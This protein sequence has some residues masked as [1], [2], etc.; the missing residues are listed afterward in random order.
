M[1]A[2][3]AVQASLCNWARADNNTI[4]KVLSEMSDSEARLLNL[5]VDGS[6]VDEILVDKE[7]K[8]TP[9]SCKMIAWVN[10]MPGGPAKFDVQRQVMPWKGNSAPAPYVEQSYIVTWNGRVGEYLEVKI[11]SLGN[12]HESTRAWVYSKPPPQLSYPQDAWGAVFSSNF[13]FCW[14]SKTL[15]QHIASDVSEW[16]KQPDKIYCALVNEVLNGSQTIK[17]SIGRQHMV[18]YDWWIDPK[19]GSSLLRYEYHAYQPDGGVADSYSG[20]VLEL[21][22]AAPEVWY[23]KEGVYFYSPAEIAVLDPGQKLPRR[24]HF[25][26]NNVVANDAK[27]DPH[28][29]D[30]SFPPGYF[31]V[32]SDTGKVNVTGPSTKELDHDLKAAAE[33]AAKASAINAK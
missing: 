21:F 9:L 17:I 22:Q 33:E 3:A 14:D 7:W 31:V 20:E 18:Q 24:M 8:A 15:S 28:V 23:P 30:P 11:G 32:D 16:H 26:A 25:K 5:Y 19:R 13:A 12:W 10:G 29:F 2:I 6:S 27:F 4:E 1:V